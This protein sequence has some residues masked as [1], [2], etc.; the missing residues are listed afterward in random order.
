MYEDHNNDLI[1]PRLKKKISVCELRSWPGSVRYICLQII[2]RI[3]HYLAGHR[4][5]KRQRRQR[6]HPRRRP[7]VF[8]PYFVEGPARWVRLHPRVASWS[9]NSRLTYVMMDAATQQA[10]QHR[11][12]QPRSAFRCC[13]RTAR[14]IPDAAKG[15]ASAISSGPWARMRNVNVHKNS[16]KATQGRPMLRHRHRI[17]L[18]GKNLFFFLMNI[19]THK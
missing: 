14:F 2:R 8:P 19:E 15:G 11:R 7:R 5:Q 16:S 17:Y 1:I 13:R 3:F 9:R 4:R 12:H 10:H 18:T 6:R